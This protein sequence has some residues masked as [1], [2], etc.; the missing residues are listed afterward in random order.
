MRILLLFSLFILSALAALSQPVR[1]SGRVT[2]A[3]TGEGVPFADVY[4]K[5]TATRPIQG[6]TADVDGYYDLSINYK[7]QDSVTVSALGYVTRTKA[8]RPDTAV[9]LNIALQSAGFDLGEVVVIAGENPANAIVRGI[10]AN[11]EKY[12][13]EALPALQY[14]N[15]AKIELDFKNIPPEWE[16][17]KAFEPF[18]II[19]ESVDSTSDEIPFLPVY[20]NEVLSDVFYVQGRTEPRE[21]VRA[22]RSSGVENATILEWMRQIHAPFNIYDNWIN[23]LEKP[24]ASPFSN[25]GLSYYEYYILDSAV[26]N[27]QWSYQLKFKPKRRQ[28]NTFYGEF[29]VADTSFAVQRVQMRM[30][31]D[32]NINLVRR[33][34][35]SEEAGI[36][37][38]QW[39]S[40]RRNMVVD[41]TPTEG[42]PGVIARRTET[43]EDFRFN[44]E[45]IRQGYQ[46]R[47][48]TQTG[49]ESSEE[50]WVAHRHEPLSKQ[51]ANIYAVSDSVQRI[52]IFKTYMEVVDIVVNGYYSAGK[53]ALGP[54]VSVISNNP[55]EGL[56]LRVGARTTTEFSENIRLG[57]HVAYGFRDERF[58]YGGTFEWI[59]NREPR[60]VIGGGFRQDISLN[61]ESSEDFLEGDV[62]SGVL[63]RP[64]PQKLIFAKEAKVFYERWGLNG[65]SN[66]VTL[67][68]RTLD[69]YGGVGGAFPFSYLPNPEN[70]SAVDTTINTTELLVK[71]RYAF[72]EKYIDGDFERTTVGTEHPIIELQYVAGLPDI[73]GSNYAYHKLSLY[74]RHY[75]TIAPIGWLS[76]RWEVGKVWG[77]V[78]FLL[79]EVHPGNESWFM[80]RGIFNTM[81]RYEF[82]SDTYASL[83]LEHHFDGFILNK[84]PLLRKLNWREIALLKG[85]VGSLSDANRQRNA[86]NLF[87]PSRV[88]T[89]NGFRAPDQGPYIEAGVGVENIFK[90]IRIDAL[91][92]IRYLDNPQAS[93]FRL[94]MGLYFYF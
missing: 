84:I 31:P 65:I 19:F 68:H 94:M 61:S 29:W 18:S 28:E 1:I 42:A 54:Y 47:P 83:I 44:E 71:L 78:P 34:I 13:P 82:A 56:R 79:M 63:R 2:D 81:N 30:S 93:R 85:V 5:A 76:Y 7:P 55:I 64:I 80:A 92:R 11:K 17:K 20:L 43:R 16:N 35:I 39:L 89:F 48:S 74:Y 4:I 49:F 60:T 50:F 62:F 26:I 45:S 9:V 33:I 10:I 25:A 88:D 12:R 72:G 32:V 14:E 46:Q 73:W 77:N 87:D 70:S 41:F 22:Q 36:V 52:P 90:I 23:V 21:I 37:N 24:F 3:D 67:L 38:G 15:Y 91:W 40:L 59:L 75:L 27:G 86:A 51:E 58:K 8:L 57:A 53:V 6:A 66:R 69:P